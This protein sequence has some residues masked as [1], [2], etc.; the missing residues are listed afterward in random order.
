M[1]ISV[2]EEDDPVERRRLV[3]TLTARLP[4][5]FGRPESNRHYAEQA[6]ILE[7]WVARR[8]G[9]AIGLLLLRRHSPVSAEIY[10]LGVAPEQH[11]RGV[12]RRLIGAVEHRLREESIRFL[13]VMTLHPDD[14]Y[15]PY[16]R[17]RAFYD[18]F[19]FVLVLS[20]A[21]GPT[22]STSN[23]LAQYLKLL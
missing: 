13:F 21:H 17:T 16:R 18:A 10:W 19:G 1:D 7:A 3:E 2:A 14:P 8:D 20:A 22:G 15:E 5:W 6:E 12:G 4:E 11:R 23:P 9:Q